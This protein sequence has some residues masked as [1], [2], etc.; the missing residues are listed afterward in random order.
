MKPD[1]EL[2]DSF[3]SLAAS[4]PG[5]ANDVLERIKPRMR[6]ARFLRRLSIAGAPLS[7]AVLLVVVFVS[8]PADPTVDRTVAADSGG[9]ATTAVAPLPDSDGQKEPTPVEVAPPDDIDPDQ[10]AN[11][12]NGPASTPIEESPPLPANTPEPQSTPSRTATVTPAPSTP[13]DDALQIEIIETD[14]GTIEVTFTESAIVLVESDP[15][16]GYEFEI[17]KSEP[18]EVKVIFRNET[19][20]IEVEIHLEDGRLSSQTSPDEEGEEARDGEDS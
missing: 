5:L 17:E 2:R 10:P 16:A 11:T 9:S 3:R 18:T 14:G 15:T 7:V 8:V 6:R 13:P 20:S 19:D 12:S 1:D 4:P